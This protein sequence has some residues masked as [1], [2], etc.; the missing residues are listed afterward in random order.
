MWRLARPLWACRPSRLRS[1]RQVHHDPHFPLATARRRSRASLP[2][3]AFDSNWIAPLGPH[4][5]AFEREFAAVVGVPHAVAL[6]S[7]T[8]ALHLAL[9]RRSASAPGDEVLVPDADVRRHRQRDHLRRRAPGLHRRRPADLERRPG[10]AGRGARRARQRGRLPIG[11]SSSSTSTASAADYDA[12]A[13]VC[14]ALRRAAHRGRRRG[15]RRD[16]SAASPP[17]R[18]ATCARLLVQ[19]QQD[20]H[21]QRRRHARL[22]R[23]RASIERARHLATQARDPAPHYEHSTIGYNYRLSNLLAAVG[24]GQLAGARPTSVARRR[25]INAS[26]ARGSSTLAGH[27]RS[28]PEAP[29]GRRTAGSPASPST[30]R[31][32]RRSARTIRARAGAAGHRVASGL[33]ADAPAAGVPRLPACAAAPSPHGSSRAACACRAA[34]AL[35]AAEQGEVIVGHWRRSARSCRS[36]YPGKAWRSAEP[37]FASDDRARVSRR[38]RRW[39]AAGW[40]SLC[41]IGSPFC[42][43]STA[44]FRRPGQNYSGGRFRWLVAIRA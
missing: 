18:S 16:L 14:R 38:A 21:H 31:V 8:A 22:A 19:R 37:Y 27:R 28:C 36:A 10:P 29:Y 9:V 26:T 44:L 5:D 7:G 17:A 43:A 23:P 24:R 13:R 6:S 30:R 12:I 32:R 3:D 25:A 39:P 15:A 1:V 2:L 35:S 11:P 20:H 34:R 4:V 33:E 41:R 42:C 40:S